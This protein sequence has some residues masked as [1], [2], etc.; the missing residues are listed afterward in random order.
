[1]ML[2][3]LRRRSVVDHGER[4]MLRGEEELL[5]R[6]GAGRE[7]LGRRRG[8]RVRRVS[9]SLTH[10]RTFGASGSWAGGC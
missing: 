5:L 7:G 9:R 6:R 3:V 10:R 2:A 4:G 1:M 8:E